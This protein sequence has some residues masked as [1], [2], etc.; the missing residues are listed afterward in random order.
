MFLLSQSLLGHL[1]LK[2]LAPNWACPAQPL[3]VGSPV[4]SSSSG[5][6]LLWGYSKT[7]W[8][9]PPGSPCGTEGWDGV[10]SHGAFILHYPVV[11]IT[12]PGSIC[13]SMPTSHTGSTSIPSAEGRGQIC[14][15]GS[16]RGTQQASSYFAGGHGTGL[17]PAWCC[18]VPGQ[19]SCSLA[20]LGWGVRDC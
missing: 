15:R 12:A 14:E 10:I 16:I 11:V 18:Q 8:T 6:L 7:I 9:H 13:S 17:W 4:P 19:G 2:G 20:C 1:L 5:N 3:F